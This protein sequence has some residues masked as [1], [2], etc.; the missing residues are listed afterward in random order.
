MEDPV[1]CCICN[2]GTPALYLAGDG[3]NR[4][5]YCK[6]HKPFALA[7]QKGVNTLTD[8]RRGREEQNE[9]LLEGRRPKRKII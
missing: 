7:H 9:L 2:D 3:R 8:Q 4:R 6:S 5:G 1:T